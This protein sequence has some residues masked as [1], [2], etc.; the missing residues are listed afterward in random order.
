MFGLGGYGPVPV[1]FRLIMPHHV[2]F[3]VCFGFVWFGLVIWSGFV[4]F[5]LVCLVWLRLVWQP[6]CKQQKS[7]AHR[8]PTWQFQV[9]SHISKSSREF[10]QN[11][12]RLTRWTISEDVKAAG[13]A[14]DPDICG[15][16]F[17]MCHFETCTN[18]TPCPK[19]SS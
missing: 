7:Q 4:W 12:C 11:L 14:T 13:R 17:Y 10:E 9:S 2:W 19:M 18:L 16:D 15:R 6:Y 5:R 3:E 1:W 8:L